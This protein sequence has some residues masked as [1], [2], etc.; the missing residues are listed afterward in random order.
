MAV[1]VILAFSTHVALAERASSPP[2]ILNRGNA[3][4][5]NMYAGRIVFRPRSE[6]KKGSYMN[7]M[8]FTVKGDVIIKYEPATEN[9]KATIYPDRNQISIRYESYAVDECL[10][11]NK[12]W[13]DGIAGGKVIESSAFNKEKEIF[14]MPFGIGLAKTLTYV[15]QSYSGKD[16]GDYTWNSDSSKQKKL[17]MFD[18]FDYSTFFKDIELDITEKNLEHWLSGTCSIP[19]WKNWGGNGYSYSTDCHWSTLYLGN[20]LGEW[21]RKK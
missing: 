6:Y 18:G 13:E 20:K 12:M 5:K 3:L 7:F 8:E 16:C 11:T 2:V 9:K 14:I 17:S 4:V 10:N 19:E 15:Q 21:R 1:I